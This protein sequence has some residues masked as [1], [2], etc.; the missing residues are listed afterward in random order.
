MAWGLK[1]VKA[2]VSCPSLSVS[3]LASSAS[4]SLAMFITAATGNKLLLLLRS[5]PHPSGAGEALG[6]RKALESGLS[7]SLLL[8]QRFGKESTAPAPTGVAH[9]TASPWPQ[10]LV[11]PAG[12]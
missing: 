8:A 10:A 4:A 3:V 9:P 5:L 11:K 6:T 1:G 7:L 12:S 2:V